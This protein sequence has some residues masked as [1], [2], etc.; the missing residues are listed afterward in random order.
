MD[1]L[2]TSN[3]GEKTDSLAIIAPNP[4]ESPVKK[5][6][7]RPKRYEVDLNKGLRPVTP[8]SEAV[9]QRFCAEFA[10]GKRWKEICGAED[11][12]S[13]D[14]IREWL[15]R[16]PTFMAAFLIAREQK[17]DL[18]I[19]EA[20]KIADDD[21]K[22]WKE[23]PGKKGEPPKLVPDWE[24]VNRSKLKVGVRQWEASRLAPL[25]WGDKLQIDGHVNMSHVNETLADRKKRVQ[26]ILAE[27]EMRG[28]KMTELAVVMGINPHY[29]VQIQK[30][31]DMIR[32]GVP[33]TFEEETSATGQETGSV[34]QIEP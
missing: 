12:P 5:R 26:D 32:K 28:G 19:D 21:S 1:F 24:N 15:S 10:E 30:R 3:Q 31:G 34:K 22:D 33:V 23:V 6:R 4:P 17:A 8:Y 7:G 25:K 20:R 2:D 14:I 11:M 27:F 16:Y 18:L 13:Q 9:A 29:F